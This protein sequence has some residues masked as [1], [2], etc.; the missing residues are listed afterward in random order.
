MHLHQCHF[1]PAHVPH[2]I[3]AHSRH[4]NP[5]RRHFLQR[6]YAVRTIMQLSQHARVIRCK[7]PNIFL[8]TWNNS[9][10]A[11]TCGLD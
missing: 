5:R 8:W 11:E 4:L 1:P 6:G 7:I 3:P 9:L 10:D 2:Y